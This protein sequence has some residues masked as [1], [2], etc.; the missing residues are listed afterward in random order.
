MY[1]AAKYKENAGGEFDIIDDEEIGMV[2]NT[3]SFG[4]LLN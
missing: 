3:E 4:C 1:Q 2:S